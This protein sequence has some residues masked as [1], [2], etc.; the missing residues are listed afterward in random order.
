MTTVSERATV[1]IRPYRDSDEPEIL[2]L[3]ARALGP[4]PVGGRIPEFWRWKHLDSP[5][6]RSFVLVAETEGRI[7]GVRPFMRW[8][9]RSAERDFN[10]V[11]AVDTATDPAEQGKGIFSR[12]TLAALDGLRDDIDFVFNTPN[13][14]SGPGYI[15][16]GWQDVGAMPVRIRVS[17]P[18]RF[19]RRLRQ[20][21]REIYDTPDLAVRAPRVDEVL[22]DPLERLL[23]DS[24]DQEERRLRTPKTV[25]YLRWRYAAVPR[26]QYYAIHTED[27]AGPTGLAIFRVRARGTLRETALAEMFVRPGDSR[28]ARRLLK[29]VA[30]AAR[31]DHVAVSFPRKSAPN[32]AA[33][34][35]RFVR[36]PGGIHFVVNHLD[37]DHM[38]D[39]ASIS[40]WALSLG[41]LEV[42]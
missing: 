1:H 27:S 23:A 4:G 15:K 2:A 16:L 37:R 26:L 20:L 31:T 29:A 10:V 25:D 14:K 17:R 39:P 11:R 6:G 32:S 21:D 24:V 28:T 13:G 9:F 40:S 36:A 12:L 22:G 3:L 41:D 38:P 7:A 42:F 35:S 33:M 18:L 19:A 34:R 8:R 5:F 30:A